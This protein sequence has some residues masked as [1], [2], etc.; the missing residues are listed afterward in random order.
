[1]EK[2][3]EEIGFNFAR[4]SFVLGAM[5]M[6]TFAFAN[7]LMSEGLSVGE[8]IAFIIVCISDVVLLYALK[9]IKD[10]F[11]AACRW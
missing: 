3:V 2:R 5:L 9:Q 8:I 6:G 10:E 11:I 7:E 1:M 4:V